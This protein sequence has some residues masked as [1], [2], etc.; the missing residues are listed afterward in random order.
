MSKTQ[1]AEQRADH[2]EIY[3]PSGDK[4]EIDPSIIP[5]GMTYEWKRAFNMGKE[6]RRNLADAMR[7][8]WAFVPADRH[9]EIG[10]E[11][12]ADMV[13]GHVNPHVGHI[14]VDGLVLM[15]RP[16]N[17]TDFVRRDDQHRARSQVAQ[18]VERLKLVPEGTLS[19]KGRRNVSL[20][21]DRDLS[22]PEDAE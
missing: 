22:I 8:K 5:D 9:P 2:F 17:I 7:N 16:V 3:R 4:Y 10:G 13:D 20:Q 18:S 6:D 11:D 1:R 14:V 12:Q 21:R 15:E 19:E